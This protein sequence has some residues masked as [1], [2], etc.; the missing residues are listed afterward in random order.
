MSVSDSEFNGR[1]EVRIVGHNDRV[2]AVPSVEV[3]KEMRRY[4]DIGELL[5]R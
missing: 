3:A 1:A 4:R 2:A 5:L